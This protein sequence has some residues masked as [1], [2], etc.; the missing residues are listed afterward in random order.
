MNTKM[1]EAFLR[2]WDRAGRECWGI[3]TP[4]IQAYGYEIND[5]YGFSEGCWR[6]GETNG[7]LNGKLIRPNIRAS[8]VRFFRD[9]ADALENEK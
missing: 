4:I 8:A 2:S 7:N 1:A 6:Y 3:L 5:S 9:L